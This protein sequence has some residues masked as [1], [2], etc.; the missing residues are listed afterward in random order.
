[1]PTVALATAEDWPDL[2]EDSAP[3]IPALAERGVD[4]RPVLWTDDAVDWTAFDVVV[5]RSVWDYFLRYERFLA[6]VAS[7]PAE[8]T[9][10]PPHLV[11]WNTHKSYLRDL[12]ARGVPVVDTVWVPPGETAAVPFE[13]AIVKP[14][15]AGG[16]EG[17]ER[18]RRGD[19]VS[20][21]DQELL[22]QPFLPSIVSEGEVSLFYAAGEL[23]HT[24][25]K[26]PRRG[27]I[28]VQPEWGGSRALEEPEPEAVAVADHLFAKLAQPV[29]LGRVDLV[30]APDGT[31]R[32]IELEIIEPRLFL[33]LA[34]GAVPAYADAIA[35]LAAPPA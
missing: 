18:R 34:P 28:R 4:A 29:L 32:V 6:W 7:L 30:R 25:R 8:R 20:A 2:D 35:A 10:N 15:V 16:A 5:I 26:V 13:D 33:T 24:V 23:T 12:E 3:L 21:A 19:A 11:R 1:M 27:D 9:W 31:L 17:L 22:V 14:A